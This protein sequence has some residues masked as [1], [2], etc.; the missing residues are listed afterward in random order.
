MKHPRRLPTMSLASLKDVR[1][2]M[3]H[4]YRLARA[5]EIKTQ[6]ATRLAYVLRQ[7]ADIIAHA[8]IEDRLNALEGVYTVKDRS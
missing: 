2:E 5:G 6:D 8:E 4:V 7:V 3:A 1:S